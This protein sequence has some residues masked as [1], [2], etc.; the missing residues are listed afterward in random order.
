MKLRFIFPA[1]ILSIITSLNC[2]DTTR[3]TS[4]SQN[5]PGS[6]PVKTKPSSSYSD[7][8]EMVLPSAVFYHADSLQIEKIKA[9]TEAGIFESLMHEFFYQMR[10]SRMVLKKYYPN[11]RIREVKNARYLLFK[12]AN[13][14]SE[15]IDLNDKNDPFGIFL[16]DGLH[17]PRLVDMTNIESELGFYFSRK[18]A[19]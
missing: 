5:D 2:S 14:E 6:N 18:P 11:I 13:G 15:L 4:P 1:F 12:K 17:S 3:R 16:F 8:V 19:R 7:T 10:N 9:V